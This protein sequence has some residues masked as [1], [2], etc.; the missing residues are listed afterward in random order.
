MRIARTREELAAALTVAPRPIGLVPTMGSLHAGHAALIAAARRD[1][2]TVVV[3]IYVNPRQFSRAADAAAYPRDLVGDT[4]IAERSGADLLFVPDDATIYPSGSMPPVV[5]PGPLAARLE[6]A[7]RPGHF[8]GVATVV[9]ILFDLVAPDAAWFGEKDAQQLRIVEALARRRGGPTIH[10]VPTVRDRDGLALSSRNALLSPSGRRAALAIP[11]ALDAAAR[12]I[13]RGAT[14]IGDLRA[15]AL[16]ELAREELTYPKYPNGDRTQATRFSVDYLDFSDGATLSPL[17][18]DDAPSAAT[19]GEL[20]ITIA[21]IVDG[22]RLIDERSI[23]LVT[24]G[25]SKR[26]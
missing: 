21:A 25:Q 20:L 18:D 14:R 9:T 10:R 3:S 4:A 6:G 16:A 19:S 11:R 8:A 15:A 12:A 26:S 24:G 5:D 7:A 23:L 1:A 13:S 22:V 17:G 2:A